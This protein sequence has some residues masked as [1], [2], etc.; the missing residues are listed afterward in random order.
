MLGKKKIT[1]SDIEHVKTINLIT[2]LEMLGYKPEYKYGDRAM[3][4]SPLRAENHP[5]FWVSKYNGSWRWKDWGTEEQGDIIK[6]VEIYHGVGFLDSVRMLLE[7]DYPTAPVIGNENRNEDIEETRL[8]KVSWIRKFYS[9][10][11]LLLDDKN[12]QRIRNYF[13]NKRVSYYPSMG[14]ICYYSFRDKRYF[15]GIPIPFTE[16][17]RGIECRELAGDG[18]KTLGCKTLWVLKRDLS[19]ILVAESI[20][21]ALAGEIILNDNKITLCSTN[22]ICNMEKIGKMVEQYGPKEIF[23]ALDNDEPGQKAQE[24]GIE[25]VKSFS[26]IRI[27]DD[28]IKAGVKDLHKLLV[29]QSS[30]SVL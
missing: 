27:V 5:S 15:I 17:I 12:I 28:H 11:A 22:G 1:E 14:C 2:Y 8:K 13:Q 18:K 26:K 30:V 9:D 19:R 20:L 10:N 4:L 3:F 16:K 21:D 29:S 25:I 23:F 6:F 24:K 7:E